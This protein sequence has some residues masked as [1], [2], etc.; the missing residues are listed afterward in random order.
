MKNIDIF[1]VSQG[2]KERFLKKKSVPFFAKKAIFPA[3]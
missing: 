3:V 1:S 2:R